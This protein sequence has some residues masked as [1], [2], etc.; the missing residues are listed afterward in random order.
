MTA[1]M[2]FG[3]TESGFSTAGSET[4]CGSGATGDK[5]LFRGDRKIQDLA[6]LLANHGV[7]YVSRWHP[8]AVSVL[9][10]VA[11]QRLATSRRQRHDQPV[12]L[13]SAALRGE[14]A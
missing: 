10:A 6:D 14:T 12:W 13:P 11:K 2:S 3:R 7:K 5:A 1:G 8:A 9:G 4:I